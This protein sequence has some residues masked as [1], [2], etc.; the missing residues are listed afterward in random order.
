M[1]SVRRGGGSRRT[2]AA[3]PVHRVSS[4]ALRAAGAGPQALHG[5]LERPRPPVLGDGQGLAVEHEGLDG[6]VAHQRDDL[7]HRVGDLVQRPRPHPHLLAAAVHLDPRAVELVLDDDLAT[8]GRR[9]SP[10]G[11][12]PGEASIGRTGRITSSPTAPSAAT[13]SALRQRGLGGRREPAGEHERAPHRVGGNPGRRR[14]RLDHQPL[15]R[16][17]A[18]LAAEQPH[19]EAALVGGGG[20]QQRRQLRGPASAHPGPRPGHRREPVQRRLDV[21]DR[22]RRLV[23]GLDVDARER[24]PADARPAL[25]HVA[26]EPRRDRPDLPG[27]GRGQDRRERGGL[28]LARAG[29]RDLRGR[30]DD[31]GEEHVRAGQ[32]S[33]RVIASTSS[34]SSSCSWVSL[35]SE[36]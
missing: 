10:P 16:A 29:R 1:R 28:G 33:T 19:E 14:H 26:R 35:P 15:E 22:Q 32:A 23:G 31:G 24:P 25:Q 17:L 34:A 21:V 7:R 18:Q 4:A 11:S 20:A 6:E 2:T 8:P 9:A 5:V 36:T 3:D 13:G 27:P 30:L 12:R